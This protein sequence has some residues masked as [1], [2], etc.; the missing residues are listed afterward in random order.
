MT[1]DAKVF[2]SYHRLERPDSSMR[3]TSSLW[4]VH[5]QV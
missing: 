2:D 1:T 5:E 4:Q 3:N